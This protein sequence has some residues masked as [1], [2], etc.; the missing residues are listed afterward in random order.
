MGA[1]PLFDSHIDCHMLSTSLPMGVTQPMPV[2]T[3]RRLMDDLSRRSFADCLEFGAETRR[4][5]RLTTQSHKERQVRKRRT[6]PFIEF[7]FALLCALCTFALM[8]LTRIP[9]LGRL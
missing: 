2:T 9:V 5:P 3:T 4:R 8:A 7:F 1:T 6:K